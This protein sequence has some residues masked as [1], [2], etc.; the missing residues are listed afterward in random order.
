VPQAAAPPQSA[1]ASPVAAAAFAIPCIIVMLTPSWSTEDSGLAMLYCLGWTL[2]KGM[3]DHH[4]EA[5]TGSPTALLEIGQ[6]SAPGSGTAGML[7]AIC[8]RQWAGYCWLA[9]CLTVHGKEKVYG[10]IS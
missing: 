2:G 7:G 6:T 9:G 4:E 5:H 10:S 3:Q 1:S 8:I